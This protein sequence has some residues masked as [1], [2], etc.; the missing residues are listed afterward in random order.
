MAVKYKLSELAKDF[1]MAP[2]EIAAFLSQY[3]KVNKNSS[4]TLSDDELNIVFD[5]LTKCQCEILSIKNWFKKYSSGI[6]ECY[7]AGAS[8][9]LILN[10]SLLYSSSKSDMR[11]A[12]SSE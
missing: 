10:Q 2:K 9:V 8:D 6:I 5:V 12:S 11:F 4:Q 3:G 1:G 7:N